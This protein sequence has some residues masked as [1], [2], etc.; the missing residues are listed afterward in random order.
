MSRVGLL[1]AVVCLV[2]IA[3]GCKGNKGNEVSDSILENE[4]VQS[5]NGDILL[6]LD[7]AYLFNDDNNPDRNTAEWNFLVKNEGRYEVWLS[8]LTL[9]TMN[10]GYNVPV[11]VNFGDKRL[12]IQPIGDEIL[13]GN[14][15]DRPY[16][17]ADSRAGSIYI[18]DPGHYN[19]QVISEKVLPGSVLKDGTARGIVTVL[20]QIKL[21]P[22]LN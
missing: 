12:E 4:V 15:A 2:V 1:A 13:L 17:R 16:F 18:N 9:D 5:G 19:I 10:L 21:K 3:G 20:D 8:S 11:I 7:D 14:G 22:L 6:A